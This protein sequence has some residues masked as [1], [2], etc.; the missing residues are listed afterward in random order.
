MIDNRLTRFFKQ[1]PHP[2]LTVYCTAGFPTLH[3]TVPI[4]ESLQTAGADIVEIGMP[5][6]DPIADGEVI[7]QSNQV[8][9]QNG[10]TIKTL[11]EQLQGF[12]QKV[13]L[14]VLLMGYIN[15]VLQYGIERFFEHAAE[16]EVDGVILPDLPLA[17]YEREYLPLCRKYN[18]SA[19]FLVSPQTDETRIRKIDDLTEGF[20]YLVSSSSTTGKTQGIQAEQINYFERI[21]QMQLKNPK[22]IGFGIAD[23]ASF[24]TACQYA[25]GAIIGSAFIKA[26]AQSADLPASIRQ[27]VQGLR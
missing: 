21:R 24:Q 16:V 10:M 22:Q 20:I 2:A 12:R 8:A 19:V 15:P 4:L 1:T 26:I 18:L 17:E 6:S 25:E 7:Q 23:K 14:P 13:H 27:F 11:F 9:L 5:F 3:D